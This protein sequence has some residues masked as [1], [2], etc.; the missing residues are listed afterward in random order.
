VSL[1][2]HIQDDEEVLSHCTTDYWAWVCTDR[3][4]L[5]YKQGSRGGEQLYDVSFGDISAISLTREGRNLNYLIGGVL[6]IALG[7]FALEFAGPVGRGAGVLIGAY[8]IKVWYDSATSYFEF[9][10]SGVIRQ[11]PDQWRIQEGSAD[12]SDAVREFVKIVRDRL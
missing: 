1:T 6:F 3:R 9:K 8:L 7:I 11:E 2:Q 12:D 10:G 4:V 5:K